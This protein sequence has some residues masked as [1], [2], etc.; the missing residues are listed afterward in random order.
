MAL[1]G[2]GAEGQRALGES[3]V[4][5]VGAGGVGCGALPLLA[6]SGIGKIAIIDGDTVSESNLHRQTLYSPGQIGEM[7]AR[8]AADARIV[9][10]GD[11]AV[12]A[13]A[14]RHFTEGFQFGGDRDR[15]RLSLG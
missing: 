1:P 14:S 7:K 4:L 10:R 12:F 8:A 2:F 13:A 15:Y 9:H 3:L 5:V 6:A 11:A